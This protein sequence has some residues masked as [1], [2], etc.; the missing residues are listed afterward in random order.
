[1]TVSQERM[2][3]ALTYLAQTDEEYAKAKALVEG[4]KES[5][6]PVKAN[7]FLRFKGGVSEREQMALGHPDYAIHI[8][9][10]QQAIQDFEYIRAKRLTETLIV[11]CWRS[12]NS[13]RGKGI[14]T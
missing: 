12:L 4:L 9:K 7:L 3:R 2:E 5:M 10:Y 11:D 14:I 1:M 13:A 8:E 6:K